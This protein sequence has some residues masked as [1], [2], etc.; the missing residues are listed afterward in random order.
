MS[1]SKFTDKTKKKLGHY[2]YR[3]V[4]PRNG[5]TFY[6]GQ[7][8]GNRVFDHARG[9]IKE[10]ENPNSKLSRIHA[11]KK[12]GLAVIHIIHRHDIPKESINEVEAAV[13]D[14]YTGLENIAG[15]YESRYRG[16]MNAE[17]LEMKLSL[18][19][20]E[21]K[22][23]ERLLFISIPKVEDPYD[24]AAVLQQ[25]E[26]AWKL[27]PKKANKADYIL[28]VVKGICY[29]AFIN[30]SGWLPATTK[31]FP[32][33]AEHL[34]TENRYGFRG[35]RAPKDVWERF[36]GKKGRL[37]IDK[38]MKTGQNPIRYYNFKIKK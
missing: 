35:K 31:N 38:E 25:T 11:I 29:G 5:E 37:V 21:N 4:D 14:A 12:T 33:R 22:P 23:N 20:I 18:K 2:I 1:I 36:V 24:V 3:L 10:K 13:I 30:E 7:G 15:G 27:D 19:P 28:S 8:T 16:P 6:V 26:L 17:E 34:S 9:E 32:N